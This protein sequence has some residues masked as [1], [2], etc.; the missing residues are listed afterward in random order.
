MFFY[1]SWEPNL[2]TTN[3][4]TNPQIY[5]MHACPSSTH[6]PTNPLSIQMAMTNNVPSLSSSSIFLICSG[7]CY[8]TNCVRGAQNRVTS[9]RTSSSTASSSHRQLEQP[10]SV[11]LSTPDHGQRSQP[12][13]TRKAVSGGCQRAL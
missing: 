6:L 2:P 13:E 7:P 1:N 10:L 11:S 8:I 3:Q 12:C 4:S 9:R 5:L